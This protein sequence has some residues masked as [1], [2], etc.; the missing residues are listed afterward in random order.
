M[1]KRSN[2]SHLP[3]RR[4]YVT[5]GWCLKRTDQAMRWLSPSAC[6][7]TSTPVRWYLG[8]QWAILITLAIRPIRPRVASNAITPRPTAN[9]VGP[10]LLVLLG[11][12]VVAPE[13]TEQ[14]SHGPLTFKGCMAIPPILSAQ[15]PRA[16][17]GIASGGRIYAQ[18]VGFSRRLQL[19]PGLVPPS[20]WSLSPV[21]ALQLF[22]R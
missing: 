10:P 4:I 2:T 20:S 6:G 5:K 15:Y 3:P 1:L 9:L 14:I 11:L 16:G 8:R 17:F 13:H 12:P 22:A 7:G 18:R 21:M 19:D